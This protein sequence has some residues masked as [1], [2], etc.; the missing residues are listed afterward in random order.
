MTIGTA[1]GSAMAEV[2]PRKGSGLGRGGVALLKAVPLFSAL[3][4]RDLRRLASNAA[5]IRYG[6]HRTIVSRGARGDSFFVIAE[7]TAAVRRGNRKIGSLGPG[8]FFG[9]MSLLDGRP[10]S[11]SVVSETPL[12][13]LRITRA[14]FNKVLDANPSIAR[15]ILT[16]LAGRIRRLESPSAN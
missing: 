13:T 14:G 11:A 3:S 6:A 16:E 2:A 9:E 4:H 15:A 5:E 10:R 1:V 7:G 8:D 12:R